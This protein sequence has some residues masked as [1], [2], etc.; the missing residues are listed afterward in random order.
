[1]SGRTDDHGSSEP[2]DLAGEAQAAGRTLAGA[3]AGVTFVVLQG[4]VGLL[5]VSLGLVA[6]PW[7]VALFAGLWVA[8]AVAGWRQRARRPV[9]TML[10]PF[11]NVGL[12]LAAVA[13]GDTWFG[14]TA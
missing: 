5:T 11:A 14:W 9:V 7:A 10:L 3:V 6:P 1:M 2:D 13:V 12:V 4:I 8:V